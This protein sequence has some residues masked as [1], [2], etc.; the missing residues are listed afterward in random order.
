M[1]FPEISG[2]IQPILEMVSRINQNQTMNLKPL[3]TPLPDTEQDLFYS[4]INALRIAGQ[5]KLADNLDQRMETLMESKTNKKIAIYVSGG[6]VQAI[7]SNIPCH[8]LDI[9]VV[10]ED[11]DPDVADDRWDEL[12]GELEFGNL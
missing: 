3:T 6:I 2:K 7:R 4:A 10:D 11:N 5:E 12:Q 1:T 9:E 8:L